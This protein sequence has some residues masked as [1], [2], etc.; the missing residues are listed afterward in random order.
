[1]M[2]SEPGPSTSLPFKMP[3]PKRKASLECP[4]SLKVDLPDWVS[5][6]KRHNLESLNIYYAKDFSLDPLEVLKRMKTV[7]DLDEEQLSYIHSVRDFLKFDASVLKLKFQRSVVQSTIAR[8]Y[9]KLTKEPNMITTMKEAFVTQ[10]VKRFIT[11]FDRLLSEVYEHHRQLKSYEGVYS[12]FVCGFA[13]LCCLEPIICSKAEQTVWKNLRGKT[14][15]SEPDFRFFKLG[16]QQQRTDTCVSIVEVKNNAKSCPQKRKR[17]RS[18]TSGTS[19]SSSDTAYSST[20]SDGHRRKSPRLRA[21]EKIEPPLIQDITTKR[22]LGQ[23]GGELLLDLNRYYG[24]LKIDILTIPGMIV[25]ETTVIFTL[26]EMSRKHLEKLKN[27]QELEEQ[28][29]ATIYYSPPYDILCEES[30]GILIENFMR[31][32]NINI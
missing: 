32:N 21:A 20:H 13:D 5:N 14:I 19:E 17:M 28:D 16:L 25:D 29:D 22:V 15:K 4:G 8:L 1:M 6:W 31:L 27:N 11:A 26:L 7:T 18:S 10:K 12:R 2:D 23:H 24:D 30:R 9:S 3:Q